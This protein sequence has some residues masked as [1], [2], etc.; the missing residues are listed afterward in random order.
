MTEVT[1][2]RIKQY[3]FTEDTLR[4]N[5]DLHGMSN[6]VTSLTD[7]TGQMQPDEL[8]FSFN[9]I[10]D[11]TAAI[12]NLIPGYKDMSVAQRQQLFTDPEALLPLVSNANDFGL[13]SPDEDGIPRLKAAAD[14]ALRTI[15]PAAFSVK[16]AEIAGRTSKFLLDKGARMNA[17]TPAGLATKVGF[18][19]T[20]IVTGAL[21]GQSLGDLLQTTVF[22]EPDPVVPAL[23][24]S[25]MFGETGVYGTVSALTMPWLMPTKSGYIGATKY[26]TNLKS[27]SQAGRSGGMGNPTIDK[28]MEMTAKAGQFSPKAI[29]QLMTSKGSRLF[30]ASKGRLGFDP[31]KGPAGVRALSAL[32]EGLV[33]QSAAGKTKTQLGGLIGLDSIAAFGAGTGA[34]AAQTAMPDSSGARLTAELAGSFAPGLLVRGSVK[35]GTGMGTRIVDGFKRYVTNKEGFLDQ[36]TA[37]QAAERLYLALTQADDFQ[38]DQALRIL[39]EAFRD[40]PMPTVGGKPE[41]ASVSALSRND[42]HGVILAKITDELTRS[43]NEL[44]VTSKKGREA[45]IQNA[46]NIALSFERSGDVEG[47]KIA[48]LIQKGLFEENIMNNM[49]RRIEVLFEALDR[50]TAG[51]AVPSG[52][53]SG[54]DGAAP[55][56]GQSR[57]DIAG[58]MY[59]SL[60]KQVVDTKDRERQ[61]WRGV[62]DFTLTTFTNPDGSSSATPRILSAF[63]DPIDNLTGGLKFNSETRKVAFE[64]NMPKGLG[65]DIELIRNYFKG[66]SAPEV[67]SKELQQAQSAFDKSFR[68]IAGTE[69]REPQF[70][71]LLDSLDNLSYDEKMTQLKIF[72]GQKKS[73]KTTPGQRELADVADKYADLLYTRQGTQAPTSGAADG[74]SPVTAKRLYDMRSA[75]LE[76]A[77]KLFR[78]GKTQSARDYNTLAQ[79]ILEDLNAQESTNAA[80]NTARAYTRARQNVFEKTFLG[81]LSEVDRKD[82]PKVAAETLLNQLFRGGNDPVVLRFNEIENASNFARQQL[83]DLYPQGFASSNIEN[84][85]SVYDD[86]EAVLRHTAK[87]VLDIRMDPRIGFDGQPMYVVN[88]ARLQKYLDNP[89]NQ[90]LLSKFPT[91]KRDLIQTGPD[92]EISAQKA[93]A[94]F[95]EIGGEKLLR[96]GAKTFFSKDPD[97]KAFNVILDNTGKPAK[98]ISSALASDNPMQSLDEIYSLV[99]GKQLMARDG[100]KLETF[101]SKNDTVYTVDE[102]IEGMKKAIFT[103]ATT[104]AGGDGILFNP[105][106]FFDAVFATPKGVVSG[107][108]SLMKFMENKGMITEGHV[109]KLK[110]ALNDMIRVNE[111]F[112]K[113]RLE[114]VLFK[115]PSQAQ[116]LQVKMIGATLGQKAQENLNGIL[117]KVGLG[118]SDNTLGGGFIAAEAGSTALQQILL[119]GPETTIIKKMGEIMLDE[120]MLSKFIL[121][122][123][124]REQLA[125][126]QNLLA[127]F[128]ADGL[129][130]TSSRA[131]P[132]LTRRAGEDETPPMKLPLGTDDVYETLLKRR[133]QASLPKPDYTRKQGETRGPRTHFRQQ[134]SLQPSGIRDL[135]LPAGTAAPSGVQTASVDPAGSGISQIDP[136]R[137]RAFF[138]SPGEITFAAR[139]GEM[140]SG[141]G[142]LFR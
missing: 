19:G 55:A 106:A 130:N 42:P 90:E 2:P 12:L 65:D 4:Q 104:Q 8:K 107:E 139:G 120:Q 110:T 50:V 1:A 62:G 26:L 102:S 80:Y 75:A 7:R 88:P 99:S 20:G 114:E 142:G 92:G 78:E 44:D 79:N 22:G 24:A 56:F 63:S 41:S 93:Q 96:E 27:I 67:I 33:R 29:Q 105:K 97:L 95:D 59:D 68:K 113:G 49:T 138:D 38:G 60:L 69:S 112:Q 89:A 141:I 21:A 11:G 98:I 126:S 14:S 39:M 111:A 9:S 58:K 30:Q 137:A 94:L 37:D 71:A 31:T 103:H 70:R 101:L 10:T 121:K 132:Y 15:L 136:E 36:R 54:V 48:S 57:Y 91:I 40:N 17:K 119:S 140:R 133:Q 118:T 127:D 5:I 74:D 52:A 61:F 87:N 76:N 116:L 115:N 64:L 100:K 72:S 16:G 128:F 47:M 32:E 109:K 82:T 6:L 45:F 73:G 35:L 18:L 25:Q 77:R 51:G 85:P 135:P 131:V 84:A 125:A 23:R 129:L 53:V 3:Q 43:S 122:I 123:Q 86:V 28:A 124:D 66:G 81:D 13:F 108:L 46:K 83:P 34:Y 134:A 117:K